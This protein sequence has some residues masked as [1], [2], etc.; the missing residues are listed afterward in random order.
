VAGEAGVGSGEACVVEGEA[1]VAGA[2]SCTPGGEDCVPDWE[3]SASTRTG[4]AANATPPS[5]IAWA[6]SRITREFIIVVCALHDA[7]RNQCRQEP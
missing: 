3:V 5:R 7:D 6:Q 4:D 2:V 1:L